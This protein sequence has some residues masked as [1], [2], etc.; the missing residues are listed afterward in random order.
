MVGAPALCAVKIP[1]VGWVSSVLVAPASQTP[2]FV[3]PTHNAALVD[4]A[5]TMG[6]WWLSVAKMAI[7][8]LAL[9]VAQ[10]VASRW[11]PSVW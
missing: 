9:S 7:V 1:I 5:S 6:A 2:T 3:S 10:G 4:S 8:A 11:C